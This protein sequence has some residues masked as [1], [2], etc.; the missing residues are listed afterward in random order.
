MNELQAIRAR[1]AAITPGVWFP[2][3][4]AYMVGVLSPET[5]KPVATIDGGPR[6]NADAAFIA[7]APADI[8]TLLAMVDKLAVQSDEARRLL[9]AV[10]AE[11]DDLAAQLREAQDA[12]KRQAA[13]ISACVDSDGCYRP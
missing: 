2:V 5:G 8:D 9:E 6:M 11:R 12:A 13:Y 3:S 1:R 7:A 4:L 10:T